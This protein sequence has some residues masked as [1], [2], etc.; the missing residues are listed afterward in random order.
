MVIK[1]N[2]K[3]VKNIKIPYLLAFP[4]AVLLVLLAVAGALFT[5]FTAVVMILLSPAFYILSK[6][7]P[8][9]FVCSYEE[10]GIKNLWTIKFEHNKRRL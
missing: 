4:L 10:I 6:V 5:V 3:I 8:W 1:K 2:G 7:L 9:F